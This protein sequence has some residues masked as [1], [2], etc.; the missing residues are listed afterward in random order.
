MTFRHDPQGMVQDKPI[1]GKILDIYQHTYIEYSQGQFL[2][3]DKTQCSRFLAEVQS[4]YFFK[5]NKNLIVGTMF[6]IGTLA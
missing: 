3:H 4:Q 5:T 6:P 1:L 2:E